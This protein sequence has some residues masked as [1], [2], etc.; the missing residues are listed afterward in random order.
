M[1]ASRSQALTE[2]AS[3]EE[4]VAEMFT[5][6]A[7]SLRDRTFEL[8]TE[9][10]YLPELT[11]SQACALIG[12]RGTGK[13]TVLKCLSY[14][15]QFALA[16]SDP[17]AIPAWAYYGIYHRV[18]TNRVTAFTGPE[19][20]EAKWTR[21]FAHYLNLLFC[22]STLA[23]LEWY[24]LH[25]NTGIVLTP[26][27][28]K[29]VGASLHVEGVTSLRALA[30]GLTDS[31]TR[32]E[33][34]INNVADGEMP[35]LSLQGQP[36]DLL[37]EAIATNPAFSGKRFFFLIDELE[38]LLDYQMRVLN[39]LI[40]HGGDHYTFKV[41][42]KE[43]GWRTRATLNENEQLISPADYVRISIAEKLTGPLFRDFAL[44]V[45]DERI[46]RL[47]DA[48]AAITT[49]QLLP[50]LGSDEEAGLL[51]GGNGIA[52]R[53]SASIRSS[54]DSSVRPAFDALPLLQQYFI[55]WWADAQ[56]ISHDEILADAILRP[57]EFRQRFDN[58]K[59]ALLFTIRAGKRGIR[60]YYAGWDE[61]ILLSGENIRYFLEL[62]D[63]SLVLHLKQG[64][65]L[66]EPIPPN[67][68]T[69]AAQR[70]GQK[71]LR[72][73]EGLFVR[74][75]QLTRLILGLGRIFQTMA[76]HPTGHA[77]EMNQFHIADD[78]LDG[79]ADSSADAARDLL[80]AAVTHLALVRTIGNKLGDEADTREYDYMVH[81][82]FA[83]FFVFSHRKKRKMLMRYDQI[84]GLVR[85]PKA[86]I[87]EILAAQNRSDTESTL[88]DQLALFESYYHA[89][90]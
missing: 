72:E 83:A 44:R 54:L 75:A 34:F 81:P 26:E 22:E 1:D 84:I 59:H 69:E 14:Q 66:N 45:C 49:R 4:R 17:A 7:E 47:T 82:I 6:R 25:T 32:F 12:G 31:V 86:T 77:P 56:K 20:P 24:E 73:L 63:N 87:R 9:P 58:Y 42:V 46:A 40:K 29:R 60:K 19:L 11:T 70:V 15:G 35:S 21:V 50:P 30:D 3:P 23:F 41:G 36:L 28:V 2:T 57:A 55:A 51:D 89:D 64:G 61:F 79:T 8:F 76:E 52:S 71:N 5:L 39:T 80:N 27:V 88:P 10:S 13:T 90:A 37:Y 38:N 62:V 74:G 43:L 53:E 18:N 78:A 48:E 85:S 16:K 67:T 33:S 68:Q 65:V